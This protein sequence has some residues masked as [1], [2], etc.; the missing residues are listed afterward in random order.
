MALNLFARPAAA[1][2]DGLVGF[3][4]GDIHGRADLLERMLE[5]LET[6]ARAVPSLRPVVVFLGDYID[7]GPASRA[8]LDLLLSGRP[9][10]FERIFL[11]GNHEASMLAFLRGDPAARA[12][13]SHGGMDTL[14]S[15]GVAPPPLGAQDGQIREAAEALRNAVPPAH[16]AFLGGLDLHHARGGY[17]FVHAGVDPDKPLEAQTERECL[18]I[19][20]PFLDS[21][22]RLPFRVVHG[23]TPVAAP[24]IDKRRIDVDTGAYA[25]GVLSAVRLEGDSAT[26]FSVRV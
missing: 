25:S 7:R 4:V 17:L 19:R 14:V 16:L 23:H 13:L 18:W 1:F 15:Y 21:R 3:A 8:C 11:M 26:T 2:P 24:F 6:E 5:R 10:G 22:R 9:S 12:W 20:S